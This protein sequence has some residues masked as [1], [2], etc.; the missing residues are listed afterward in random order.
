VPKKASTLTEPRSFM[1]FG[2]PKI[3][4]STLM[5]SLSN[6][7][8]YGKMAVI[9]I[10][11]GAQAYAESAPNVDVIPIP[12]QD[13][14]AFGQV[15]NDLTGKYKDMYQAVGIDTFTTL[16]PWLLRKIAGQSLVNGFWKQN[17]ASWDN[18]G[19]VADLVLDIAWQMH[20]APWCGLML[21]HAKDEK[22]A[23]TGI[24]KKKPALKGSARDSI[25]AVAD[26]NLYMRPHNMET[27][28]F[29]DDGTAIMQT[30]RIARFGIN[31]ETPTGNRVR[32]PEGLT[33]Q[34]G[35]LNM[36]EMFRYIRGE[37][38]LQDAPAIPEHTAL[39]SEDGEPPTE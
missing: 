18:W 38:D 26:V 32:L 35:K 6:V 11:G 28:N 15:F 34:E 19:E 1:L 33:D 13:A 24:D 22:D 17:K 16:Q 7:K 27:G 37:V 9:D 21:F 30:I 31:E 5:A 3:G 10:D 14:D 4:K 12:Y 39:T 20:Y 2:T 8:G 25:G 29:T 36:P 23:V